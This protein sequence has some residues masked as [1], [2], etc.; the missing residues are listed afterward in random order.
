MKAPV[1]YSFAAIPLPILLSTMADG[2]R[3]R[4]P[5]IIHKGAD[6]T[7]VALGPTTKRTDSARRRGRRAKQTLK[8]PK[9]IERKT[10]GRV[11]WRAWFGDPDGKTE[12][13]THRAGI[14]NDGPRN[15]RNTRKP[16]APFRVFGVF[17]GQ[18]AFVPH[19]TLRFRNERQN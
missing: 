1:R 5:V 19:R 2:K 16:E 4:S 15:T 6:T 10:L 14:K 17:R 9:R 13:G 18:K 7:H 12:I 11:R 3:Q 8:P